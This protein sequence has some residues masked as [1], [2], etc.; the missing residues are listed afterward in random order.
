MESHISDGNNEAL[1]DNNP[2]HDDTCI[3]YDDIYHPK[4][5][6]TNYICCDE[7]PVKK[8]TCE[9][10]VLLLANKRKLLHQ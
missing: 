2:D 3:D 10:I 1:G 4:I 9:H 7:Y 8:I 5:D 6:K